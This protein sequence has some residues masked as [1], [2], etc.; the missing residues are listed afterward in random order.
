MFIA[1]RLRRGNSLAVCVRATTV[2]L[3]VAQFQPVSPARHGQNPAIRGLQITYINKA[4]EF[5]L[6]LLAVL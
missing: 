3:F 6:H 2:T 1:I 4:V 5:V